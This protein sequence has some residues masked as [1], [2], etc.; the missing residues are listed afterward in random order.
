MSLKDTTAQGMNR[1]FD[2]GGLI[3][4]N[5]QH[6]KSER[7]S[8]SAG[9]T[10]PKS[11]HGHRFIS[12]S[13]LSCCLD[14]RVIAILSL[15]QAVRSEQSAATG[16][17]DAWAVGGGAVATEAGDVGAGGHGTE[18]PAAAVRGDADRAGPGCRGG[19]SMV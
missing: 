8:F 7:G 16:G 15:P 3:L 5:L 18:S 11:D 19:V 17:L 4:E 2:I 6:E 13:A 9:G 10:S 1:N 12:V 14:D